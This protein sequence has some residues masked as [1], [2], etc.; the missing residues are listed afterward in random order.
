MSDPQQDKLYT[1]EYEELRGHCRH[2]LPLK[3]LRRWAREICTQFN[4]PPITIRIW[5]RKGYDA[6][7]ETDYHGIQLDP[8]N[9]RNALTLAHELAHHLVAMKNPRAQDHGPTYCAY[10]AAILDGFRL[11]PIAGFKAIAKK[12][13]VKVGRLKPIV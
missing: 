4:V 5:K 11:V 12:Y 10:Y 8:S 7:Y 1:M 9:G 6:S 2:T 3:K 13:K